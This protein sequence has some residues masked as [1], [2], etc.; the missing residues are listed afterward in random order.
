MGK[1][2]GQKSGA[3]VPEIQCNTIVALLS[4]VPWYNIAKYII[5]V[6]HCMER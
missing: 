2:V 6:Q 5:I 4:I 1:T 3:A